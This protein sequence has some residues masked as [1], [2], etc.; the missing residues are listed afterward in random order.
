MPNNFAKIS[1]HLIGT[2]ALLLLTTL[3]FFYFQPFYLPRNFALFLG[4]IFAPFIIIPV[5]NQ[6]SNRFLLPTLFLGLSLFFI[7]TNS[8]YYGFGVCLL[9]YIW[10]SR[11]G[12]LN[13]LPLFLFGVLSFLVQQ[14]LTNWSFPIRLQLS[15]LAGKAI[16]FLGY[17]ITVTGNL[18]YLDGQPFSVDPACM[19]LKMMVTAQLLALVIFAYFERKNKF[20][21]SFSNITFGLV[22]IILLTILANFIRL[23]ALIIFKIMPDN[24]LHD[25]MGLISLMVYALLPFYFGVQ[26]LSRRS[27]ASRTWSSGSTL[28]S[29]YLILPKYLIRQTQI[30]LRIRH[31]E[32]VPFATIIL[33]S[34]LFLYQGIQSKQPIPLFAHPY[35]TEKFANFKQS[36]TGNGMLKLEN[37]S[38]LVYIKPPVSFFQGSHDPRVCWKGSGY[39]FQNIQVE[40]IDDTEIYT[41]ILEHQEERFYTAWWYDNLENTTIEEWQW[42]M[43]GLKG[44]SGYFLVNVSSLN[45][46]HLLEQVG[47]LLK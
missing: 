37:D 45:R 11:Q 6:V 16:G 31:F 29:P 22:A 30:I 39:T 38:T 5:D 12:R 32:N 25:M 43:E 15:V 41:A 28:S 21:F 23:L 47:R 19:G 34:S 27:S 1:P 9:L 40:K 44:P 18:I 17:P 33:L 4:I 8:L 3:V 14:V 20:V 26:F 13:N 46:K 36:T 24:P 35:P 2:I 42:R 7:K 10:E